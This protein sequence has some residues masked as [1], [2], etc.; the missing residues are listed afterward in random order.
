M[1]GKAI[2]WFAYL[3]FLACLQSRLFAGAASASDSFKIHVDG[4]TLTIQFKG[5]PLLVHAFGP[6]KP[7][8]R[9]LYTLRG[10]NVLRNAPADHLHHH[11]LMYAIRVND[12]NFWE[13]RDQ[14]GH[15]IPVKL[16]SHES[17]KTAD[18]LPTASFSQVI[19]WVGHTNMAAANSESVA[20]LVERRTLTLMVDEGRSEVALRWQAEFEV[21][22]AAQK[23]KLHGSG[24]NGLGLRLPANWDHVAKHVNSEKAPYSTEQKWDVIPARWASVSHIDKDNT[25][26]VALLGQPSNRGDT[27][28]FSM[29]NPFAYLS[30]TQNLEKA[31]LEYARGEKFQIDYLVL[32]YPEKKSNE[33]LEQRYQSWIN[34]AASK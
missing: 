23:A 5:Q 12:V 15:Q 31:P 7:Y 28:F 2:V 17:G 4:N 33:F 1:N 18:G 24:Y 8:V 11:G 25:T 10:D 9:E 21:G 6:F 16:L 32:V 3:L 14:P 30:V 29:L 20:L 19:H 34:Q 13:E 26:T 22:P 27:R